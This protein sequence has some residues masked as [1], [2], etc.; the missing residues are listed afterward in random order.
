MEI[1]FYLTFFIIG[2]CNIFQSVDNANILCLM[3]VPS[4]SHHI[5]NQ[6]LV[7][8][9][10]AKGHNVTVIS[11]NIKNAESNSHY[12]ELEEVYPTVFNGPE[13][14]DLFEMARVNIFESIP[15]PYTFGLLGCSGKFQ[16][17]SYS[18]F[19]FNNHFRYTEIKWFAKATELY[20]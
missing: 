12:L 20:Q 16:L 6:V 3:D 17:F 5:W 10:S 2:F 9:L 8:E 18:Y 4:I 1:Q 11:P 14:L 7:E 15:I 19:Y 13:A